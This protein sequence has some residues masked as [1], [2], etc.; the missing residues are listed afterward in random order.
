MLTRNQTYTHTCV[1]ALCATKLVS[2]TFVCTLR[3]TNLAAHKTKS[4]A[5]YSVLLSLRRGMI[6][7]FWFINNNFFFIINISKEN[8]FNTKMIENI[9]IHMLHIKI[10][11]LPDP[12]AC[13]DDDDDDCAVPCTRPRVISVQVSHRACQV[14]Q[15]KLVSYHG[16]RALSLSHSL[17]VLLHT[18]IP[19]WINIRGNCT[20]FCSTCYCFPLSSSMQRAAATAAQEHQPAYNK[21]AHPAS[22]SLI[23]VRHTT[24]TTTTLVEHVQRVAA[25]LYEHLHTITVVVYLSWFVFF[26]CWFVR[27]C[28]GDI[29]IE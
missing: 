5:F 20:L 19:L 7:Q 28:G 24:T 3:C 18:L 13:V 6:H 2:Q 29:H 1:Y 14:P 26:F 10:D 8:F 21:N 4:R 16:L 27:L 11:I 22:D 9:N 12:L 15:N 25:P 23:H 17:L